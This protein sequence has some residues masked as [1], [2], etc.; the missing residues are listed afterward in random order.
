MLTDNQKV[1]SK[2]TLVTVFAAAEEVATDDYYAMSCVK[3]I[4]DKSG[5]IQDRTVELVRGIQKTLKTQPDFVRNVKASDDIKLEFDTEK[6]A[7]E[8]ATLINRDSTSYNA[9]YS[10][11]YDSN[12]LIRFYVTFSKR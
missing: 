11:T 9:T 8:T 12:L 2:L 7:R 6:S 5:W 4:H 10:I 3:D 1:I